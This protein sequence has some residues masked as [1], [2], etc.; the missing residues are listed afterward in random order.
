MKFENACPKFGVSPPVQIEGQNHLFD[1]HMMRV[2][3]RLKKVIVTPVVYPRFLKFLHIDIQS[4]GRTLSRPW[5]RQPN[6]VMCEI[7]CAQLHSELLRHT[8]S[9]RQSHSLLALAKHLLIFDMRVLWHSG[10]SARTS[11]IENGGLD[12]YGAEPFEQQQLGTAGVEGVKYLHIVL[13]RNY[14]AYCCCSS[15]SIF[16]ITSLKHRR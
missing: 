10:L 12:Q 13:Y 15:N 9:T 7:D 16:I 5:S 4:T 3:Q 2:C 14:Q 6:D 11:K 8:H 1:Y